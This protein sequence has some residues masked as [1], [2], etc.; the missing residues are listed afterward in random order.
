MKPHWKNVTVTL[1]ALAMKIGPLDK[2]GLDVVY[3]VG[4]SSCNRSN[5]SQWS[6]PSEFGQSM[7]EAQREIETGDRTDMATTLKKLFDRYKN[8]SKKQTL[9]ILTDGLWE[10]SNSKEDVETAITS[11]IT[12]VK[13]QLKKYEPRW[14]SIQFISFGHDPVALDRLRGLDD[15]LKTK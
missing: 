8:M 9:I 15:D 4:D 10:G 2:D 14:F 5:V 12:D 7:K 1:L 3:T 6:I 13:R 11:F